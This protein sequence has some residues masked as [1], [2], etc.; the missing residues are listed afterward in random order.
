[1]AGNIVQAEIRFLPIAPEECALVSCPDILVLASCRAVV[2]FY[3]LQFGPIGK[4]IL[5][6]RV[7]MFRVVLLSGP[8]Q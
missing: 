7:Q 5:N 1:M 4:A 8:T 2:E 3:R 6:P